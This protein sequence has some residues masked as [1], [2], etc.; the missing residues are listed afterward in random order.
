MRE[1]SEKKFCY[2]KLFIASFMFEA[3]PVFNSI[4]H[5]YY[6]FTYDVGNRNSGGRAVKSRENV[7]EFFNARR[8]C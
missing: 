1:M 8:M 7:G 4:V 2:G 3:T 5:F 6:T